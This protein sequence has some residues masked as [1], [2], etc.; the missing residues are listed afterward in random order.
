MFEADRNEDILCEFALRRKAR[1]LFFFWNVHI[2]QCH[3]LV[4]PE[5]NTDGY[6]QITDVFHLIVIVTLREVVVY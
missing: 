4:C 1:G 5:A 6:G 3:N 2:F